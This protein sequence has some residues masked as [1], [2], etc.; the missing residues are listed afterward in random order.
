MSENKYF[1]ALSR[2]SIKNGYPTISELIR[3]I[4]KVD[5]VTILG[6]SDKIVTLGYVGTYQELSKAIVRH[7]NHY[8]LLW[9]PDSQQQ[10]YY[11]S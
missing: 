11:K 4:E 5:G 8:V 1:V 2:E 6:T 9:L 3:S 10:T 7:R